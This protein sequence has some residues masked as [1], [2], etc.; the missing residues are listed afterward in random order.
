M[1]KTILKIGL[2]FCL[3]ASAGWAADEVTRSYGPVQ[4]NEN[5]YG[6]ASK[7][8][9]KGVTMPQ[10]MMA[11]FE[12]NP[13][14]FD[15]QNINR[16][17]VGSMLE[18][19]DIKVAAKIN[20]KKAYAQ[21]TTHIDTFEEE[22]REVKVESG[23]LKPLSTSPRDPDL[24]P[25]VLITQLD[26]KQ[27]EAIKR[28]LEQEQVEQ[29]S[30]VVAQSTGLPEPKVGT[31]KKRQIPK[32][33]LFNFSY[34]VAYVNDDN[35]RL[36]QDDDDIREDSIISAGI[37]ARGGKSL[38]SHSIWN[39]G[40]SATYNQ[41]ETF[42]DL[43]H[44]EVEAN[45]RYRFALSSGFTSP[46]Y[47]LGARLSGLEFDSEMRD[48]TIISL[49]AE[50]TK[51]LTS[52]L[53]M[54][55]GIGLKSRESKSETYDTEETRIFVNIDT[56]LS[57]TDLI[58]TTLTYITGDT[59]SSAT[60]TLDI[61]NVSDSIEPD[62]AFGGIDTNQFAYRIDSETYVITAGYNKIYSRDLSFDFSVR[63]VET[64][65]KDDSSIGYDRTIFRASL[66]GRF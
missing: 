50:L 7:Y 23:E 5:L 25:L 26:L 3:F 14:A 63:L 45:T 37:K 64:E 1:K 38:D 2:I 9:Q 18:I 47:T 58:Y 21:A 49:S 16:L 59:V 55:T 22:V 36:A 34:D 4:N 39:Y 40:A 42:D 52:T 33:P 29:E 46:I 43:N 20:P 19:P 28:E 62:D 15:Q 44:Y 56:N 48:S 32:R 41:F 30:A 31:T 11:I 24:A 57:K 12:R 13:D 53:N 60:P 35:V 17:K 6:I 8:R 54:T 66:L 65:A 51:W 10:L 61:I 27:L